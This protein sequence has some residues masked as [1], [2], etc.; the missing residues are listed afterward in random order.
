MFIANRVCGILE[1]TNVDEWNYLATSDNL[2][3]SGKRDMSAEVLQSS[4]WVRVPD[5]LR[6]NEIAFGLSS[7]IVKNISPVIIKKGN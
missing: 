2:S 4:N 3:D 1:N 6:T 5:F 7:E